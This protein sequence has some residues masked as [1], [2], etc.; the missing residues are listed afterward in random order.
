MQSF[1]IHSP[2]IYSNESE[3]AFFLSADVWRDFEGN[4]WRDAEKMMTGW[5][6]LIMWLLFFQKMNGNEN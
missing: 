2:V 6:V 1:T 3:C 5:G 4:L